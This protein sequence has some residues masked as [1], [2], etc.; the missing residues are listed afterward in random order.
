[1]SF[2]I[3]ACLKARDVVEGQQDVKKRNAYRQK[4]R[5]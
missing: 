2:M 4:F 1:M 5:L 3:G